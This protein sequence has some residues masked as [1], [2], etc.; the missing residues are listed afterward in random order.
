MMS[1]FNHIWKQMN[2]NTEGTYR[3]QALD[4]FGKIVLDIKGLK[5]DQLQIELDKLRKNLKFQQIWVTHPDGYIE[6]WNF[7]KSRA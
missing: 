4:Y 3:I 1:R 5:K 2:T 6:R 7:T